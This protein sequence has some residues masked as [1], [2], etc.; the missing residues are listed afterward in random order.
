MRKIQRLLMA[1]VLLLAVSMVVMAGEMSG[2]P[3]PG[4]MNAPPGE[5]QTPPGETQAPPG[6]TQGPPLAFMIG[7]ILSALGL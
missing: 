1:L 2:P 6:E 5:T 3:S 7:D 4:E